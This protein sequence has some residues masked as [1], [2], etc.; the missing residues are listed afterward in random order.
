[1]LP[2]DQTKNEPPDPAL[3]TPFLGCLDIQV[4]IASA[5]ARCGSR[6]SF[7][8]WFRTCRRLYVVVQPAFLRAYQERMFPAA[9]RFFHRDMQRA[10]AWYLKHAALTS[11]NQI[12]EIPLNAKQGAETCTEIVARFPKCRGL[13]IEQS[14]ELT[15]AT[16]IAIVEKCPELEWISSD[17]SYTVLQYI[18]NPGTGQPMAEMKVTPKGPSRCGDAALHALAAYCPGLKTAN[19]G[20]WT[21]ITDTGL[22]PLGEGCSSLESLSLACCTAIT[23]V[24]ICALTSRCRDLKKLDLSV[25]RSLTDAAIRAVA[26][27]CQK[28]TEIYFA[29][30]RRCTTQGLE[31]LATY[32]PLL[33]VVDISGNMFVTD[34]TVSA[35]AR[36]SLQLTRLNLSGCPHVTD[37][38]LE[39]LATCC[40][41]LQ[42][43]ELNGCSRISQAGLRA[44]KKAFPNLQFVLDNTPKAPDFYISEYLSAIFSQI[45]L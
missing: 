19:L 41:K 25:C 37:R 7:W 21:A 17:A 42:Q 31:M 20:C 45:R 23:D 1:M 28:L 32:C 18:R 10:S 39:T 35:F 2:Q 40:L 4:L 16:V 15:D 22:K 36:C 44:L 13:S 26:K 6:D 33:S 8:A 43:I 11:I 30:L 29:C 34:E 38:S 27:N 9:M 12:H 14:M 3:T 5:I 24:G